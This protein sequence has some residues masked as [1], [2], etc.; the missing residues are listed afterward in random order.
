MMPRMTRLRPH[1]L[2]F[3]LF[4]T[5]STDFSEQMRQAY[6]GRGTDGILELDLPESSNDITQSILTVSNKSTGPAASLLAG[7]L[8][9]CY[10]QQR[11][12]SLA[13]QVYEQMMKHV[14][15][16]VVMWSL[17]ANI[18]YS[19]FVETAQR[20]AKK[21][22][23]TA[24]RKLLAASRRKGAALSVQD[25]TASIQNLLGPEFA[26]LYE[27]DD[28][29]VVNK[30]AGIVSFH[31][32]STG[33]KVRPGKDVSLVDAMVHANVKLS[34]LNPDALGLVHRLDRGTSGCMMLAKS[35]EAHARLVMQLF[36]RQI[37]K[38]YACKVDK[39][40]PLGL[41]ETPVHDKP[42]LSEVLS[43][44]NGIV[45]MTI[46]TG[47]KHQVRIHCADLGAPIVG[48]TL[49]GG[50]TLA[51]RDFCLH[52]TQ[53]SIPEHGTITSPIP[54]WWED[55]WDDVGGSLKGPIFTKSDRCLLLWQGETGLDW[56]STASINYMS[57][58]SLPWQ[59]HQVI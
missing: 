20:A 22:A 21:K 27:T 2:Q 5:T 38:E 30:P 12:P 36:C 23:G 41:V 26:V 6:H 29:V 46:Q 1:K 49:Y 13:L 3:T 42:A 47:R 56:L 50:R 34:T 11:S 54:E 16:D 7:V 57:A 48:D 4:S 59:R 28:L 51:D 32:H 9:N 8:G 39:E 14:E 43:C 58:S 15:P 25:A 45:Q 52:C 53:L 44:E 40:V 17:L 19:D 10:L 35:D 31:A 37:A 18:G 33:G 55:V 24:R